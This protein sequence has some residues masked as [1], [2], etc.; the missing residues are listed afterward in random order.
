[1]HIVFY[2][3]HIVPI[4]VGPMKAQRLSQ[5]RPCEPRASRASE[6]KSQRPSRKPQL[7]R[8]SWG[9]SRLQNSSSRGLDFSV[10]G[11]RL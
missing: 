6:P 7:S 9:P 8:G 3:L 2:I 11:F 5:T 4:S 10:A 1:M